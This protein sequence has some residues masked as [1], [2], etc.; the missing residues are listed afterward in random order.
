MWKFEFA[1]PYYLYLFLLFI[2][3][4]AWYIWK[5][6]S[7]YASIQI[8]S[9]KGFGSTKDYTNYLRHIN[10]VLR[11]LALSALIIALAR[12][13]SSKRWENIDTLGIDIMLAVD[14]SSSMLARDFKPDRLEAAKDVAIEFIA[15]RPNDRIGLIV[16]S[17]ESFTQCPLTIDHAVLTNLFKDIKSGMIEDGTA[18][19]VGMAN[20]IKRLKDSDAISKVIILLTDGENNKGA[21]DPITAAELA[22]TFNIRVYT[23]GVGS[24]GTAPYPVQDVFGRTVLQDVPVEID[25]ETLQQIADITDGRYFRAVNNTKLKEIYQEIDQLEKSRISVKEYNRKEE[26]FLP[27]LLFGLIVLVIEFIVNKFILRIIP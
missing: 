23:V 10:A 12:P 11:A 26:K 24:I 21:I 14:V 6:N 20:A 13:Q 18:I 5:Q 4:I 17:G 27:F 22:K 1:N 15:G 25:E 16:F 19:G 3:L 8:S 2:P 7:I 9:L